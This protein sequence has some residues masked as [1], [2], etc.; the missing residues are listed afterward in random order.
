MV[1]SVIVPS[2]RTETIGG[3]ASSTSLGRT[4]PTGFQIGFQQ[5]L[6]DHSTVRMYWRPALGIFAGGRTAPQQFG[7]ESI[8]LRYPATA[9]LSV[10]AG[11]QWPIGYHAPS[12]DAKP[13]PRL[14]LDVDVRWQQSHLLS[15]QNDGL[16][17]KNPFLVT[18]GVSRRLW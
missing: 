7:T 2:L 15:G 18:I 17:W 13:E 14:F 4:S 9:G 12:H 6:I 3:S 10:G 1:F 11:V 16:A 8:S 5:Y